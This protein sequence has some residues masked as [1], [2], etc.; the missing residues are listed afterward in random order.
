MKTSTFSRST[1]PTKIYKKPLFGYRAIIWGGAINHPTISELLALTSKSD[2]SITFK[3]T[4]EHFSIKGRGNY[5]S[6]EN[7]KYIIRDW[8]KST[9]IIKVVQKIGS[10]IFL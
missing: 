4:S 9:L 2:L 1:P 5:T 7:N 10:V 3:L 8:T 6:A